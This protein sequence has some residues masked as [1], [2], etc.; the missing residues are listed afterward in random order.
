MLHPT[1]VQPR[2]KFR[3]WLRYS[4]GV[5]GELDLSEL[6]GRGMFAAWTEP[7]VFERVHIA[8]HRAIAWSDDLELCPDALYMELTGK[9]L[10]DLPN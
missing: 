2:E 9:L 8:P 5:E 4:D 7:G 10:R 6:A 3:L 1:G